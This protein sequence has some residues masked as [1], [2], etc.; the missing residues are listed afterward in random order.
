MDNSS[1]FIS[2]YYYLPA[3]SNKTSPFASYRKTEAM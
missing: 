3:R 2:S 1:P